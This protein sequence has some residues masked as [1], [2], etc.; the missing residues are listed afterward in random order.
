MAPVGE[1]Q[2]GSPRDTGT[3]GWTGSWPHMRASRGRVIPCAGDRQALWEAVPPAASTWGVGD[4]REQLSGAP[5]VPAG[6]VPALET[7]AGCLAQLAVCSGGRQ[8]LGKKAGPPAWWGR[9]GTCSGWGDALRQPPDHLPLFC[10]SGPVSIRPQTAGALGLEGRPT[11][12]CLWP[13]A[14][15]GPFGM[16]IGRDSLSGPRLYLQQ[17]TRGTAGPARGDA[18]CRGLG[19]PSAAW[20][21]GGSIAGPPFLLSESPSCSQRRLWPPNG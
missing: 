1:T 15:S 8:H 12:P 14:H 2:C 21:P 11:Q 19:L 4:S 5:E 18:A 10:V 16:H 17:G 13:E 9:K 6:P 7:P 20:G 3:E